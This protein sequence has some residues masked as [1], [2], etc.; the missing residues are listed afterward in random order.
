MLSDGKPRV[1]EAVVFYDGECGLC[2]K[3]VQFIIPRDPQ[4]RFQFA[5]LQSE[6]GGKLL[7]EHGYDEADMKTFVL[8]ES[9]RVYTRSTAAL[10]VARRLNGG[11]PLLYG[12][13]IVPRLL[14]D[15]VYHVIANNRYRWFGKAD[16]CR[17]PKPGERGR[18]L[19]R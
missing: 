5:A 13:V 16:A 2:D 9:G 11:W 15:G 17:L 10:R 8:L 1:G 6:I 7:R 12:L 19:D 14:R 18:F 4:G 3:A